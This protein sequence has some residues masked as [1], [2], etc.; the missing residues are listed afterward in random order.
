M[1]A[2]LAFEGTAAQAMWLLSKILGRITENLQALMSSPLVLSDRFF[3]GYVLTFIILAAIVFNRD[4][5]PLRLSSFRSFLR[6]AFPAEVYRHQSARIDLGVFLLNRGLTPAALVTR[7]WTAATLAMVAAAILDTT[8]GP[9]EKLASPTGW[10]LLLFTA[11]SVLAFDFADF[12]AH[13]LMHRVPVLWEFHK[14][15]H[16]AEVLTP[17]TVARI[18]P[19]EQIVGT[20]ISTPIAGL[21]SGVG[22]YLFLTAPTP[23]TL[24]GAPAAQ[25]LFYAAGFHLRHSH[26]WLS[27]GPV[28]GRIL[29]SP[30]QHQVHH[31]RAIEHTN[32]NFG[33]IFAIWD[34]IFG[35]LYLTRAPEQLEFGLASADGEEAHLTITSAYWEPIKG[36]LAVLGRTARSPLRREADD[37]G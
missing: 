12:A 32:R 13:V 29:I 10:Q 16:S 23:L 18:H 4:F 36:A 7:W 19:L 14:L 21:V 31:S 2:A 37:A 26:V 22:A 27:W 3:M 9:L 25:V 15:H 30:A 11:F 6:F 20:V 5:G 35:T 17:F 8:F 24:L 1:L 28:V 34:W 33:F